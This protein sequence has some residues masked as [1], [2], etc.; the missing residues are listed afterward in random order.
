MVPAMNDPAVKVSII[1][2]LRTACPVTV[3]W[4]AVVVARVEV[5]VTV[6]VP[7]EVS[8]EVA[9][10]DPAVKEL[11]VAV[12]ALRTEAKRLV[13][14]ALVAVRLVKNAVVALRRVAKKFEEV[15]LVSVELV[16]VEL[17]RVAPV[18]ERFVVEALPKVVWPVTLSVPVRTPLVYR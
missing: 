17:V 5:P 13:L 9:V 6:S 3:S 7:F 12:T 8:E 1:A 15:A 2:L 16:S 10:M 11:T 4:V 14:V 18:A